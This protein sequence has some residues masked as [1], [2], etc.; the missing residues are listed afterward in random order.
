MKFD[1]KI[2]IIKQL[3]SETEDGF[4]KF[5]L[6]SIELF[7]NYKQDD[8]QILHALDRA[9]VALKLRQGCML[10][11]N[12]DAE[13]CYREQDAWTLA[14]FLVA[15]LNNLRSEFLEMN[16]GM[17][18]ISQ[19]CMDF[20]YEFKHSVFGEFA[21]CF[22]NNENH[23]NNPI[24]RIISRAENIVNIQL[25]KKRKQTNIQLK[26]GDIKSD[27]IYGE[28]IA[29]IKLGISQ[30]KFSI[31]KK[32]SI[33]HRVTD[34]LFLVTPEIVQIFFKTNNFGEFLINVG[35]QDRVK[36]FL[37][38]IPKKGLFIR[39]QNGSFIHE[40]YNGNWDATNY[41]AGLLIKYSQLNL[42][43]KLPVNNALKARPKL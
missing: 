7:S 20:L 6:K 19:D 8:K 17:K 43:K 1:N 31:N 32:N 28:F 14:V 12:S 11:L 13:T 37:D 29:W 22:R 18:L 3:I 39:H 2:Q 35:Y 27:N 34:G 9:I 24:D 42:E 38:Q 33:V 40:Y 21:K 16:L 30:Q 25:N 26:T 10:P 4:V 36:D 23:E 15:L 41:I 5:Y